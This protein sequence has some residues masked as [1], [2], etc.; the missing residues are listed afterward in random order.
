MEV[1]WSTVCNCRVE[2]NRMF[3]NRGI[4]EQ[5]MDIHTL[6]YCIIYKKVYSYLTGKTGHIK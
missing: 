4:G 6:E 3:T 5:I 2:N 1:H